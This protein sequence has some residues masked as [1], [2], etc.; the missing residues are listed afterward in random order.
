VVPV[1][2]LGTPDFDATTAVDRTSLTF[3]RTGDEASFS[4]CALVQ[5]DLN[6]DGSVDLLCYFHQQ[7]TGFVPGDTQG[8]LRGATTEGRPIQGVDVVRVK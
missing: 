1:A 5:S 8:V 4:H 7:A 2:I 3:G 6:G